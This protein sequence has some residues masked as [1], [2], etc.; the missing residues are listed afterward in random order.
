[1]TFTL[2]TSSDSSNFFNPTSKNCSPPSKISNK[3]LQEITGRYKK[4]TETKKSTNFYTFCSVAI[5]N[6]LNVAW[7]P[8]PA[9]SKSTAITFSDES[10]FIANWHCLILIIIGLGPNDSSKSRHEFDLFK[11]FAFFEFEL[12]DVFCIFAICSDCWAAC[13]F[14][15]M[16]STYSSS[17]V[18]FLGIG[19]LLKWNFQVL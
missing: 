9:H 13:L 6:K 17:S 18:L 14:F 11:S 3:Y 19:G 5:C 1:M 15:W 7:R 12:V 16:I 2:R 8:S 10:S 4:R